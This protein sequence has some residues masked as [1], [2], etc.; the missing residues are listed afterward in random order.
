MDK[1]APLKTHMVVNKNIL[2]EEWMSHSLIKCSK[3]CYKFY[4]Y[5]IGKEKDVPKSQKYIQY[6][7]ILNRLKKTQK[8]NYYVNK[9]KKL[10][11]YI[12]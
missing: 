2:R 3:K 9:T 4:K 7:N 8:R 5:A 1:H 12:E 6:R 11:L 10:F